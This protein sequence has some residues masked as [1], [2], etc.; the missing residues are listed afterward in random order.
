MNTISVDLQKQVEDVVIATYVTAKLVFGREF[1]LPKIEYEDMGC[2]GGKAFASKNLIKL[3]PT[4]LKENI[5]KYLKTT[6]PHEIAHL[7]TRKMYSMATPHGRHWKYVMVKLGAKPN[8]CHEYDVSNVS[9]KRKE[10]FKY[11]YVCNCRSHMVTSVIHNRIVLL[12]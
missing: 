1:D 6:V 5:E 4:L 12:G 8:R 2:V 9:N 7:L 10:R 3:S 11:H